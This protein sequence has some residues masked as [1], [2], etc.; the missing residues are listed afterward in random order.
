LRTGQLPGAAPPMVPVG[1]DYVN[2][3]LVALERGDPSRAASFFETRRRMAPNASAAGTK[4]RWL[5]WN[6]TLTGTALAAVG[7]TA[8]V[9]RLVDTV[10]YWGERSLFARDRKAHHFL[11]G[12]LLVAAGRD[13]DATKEYY[14]AIHSYSLGYT[15]INYELAKCLLRL[16]RP[17]EAVGVLQ[18]AL[19]G[20]VDAANMYMTRTELHELLAQAFDRAGQ[21]DSAAAHYRAV[22]RAWAHADPRFAARREA[23]QRALTRMVNSGQVRP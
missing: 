10:E 7:D 3:A 11:R 6:T 17:Q 23:V 22:A 12:L 19:R 9:R 1:R 14:A 8:A 21:P 13:E 18:P 16:D 4:A 2:E 15:R 5:A 20:E